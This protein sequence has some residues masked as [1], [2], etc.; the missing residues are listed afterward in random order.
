MTVTP[1]QAREARE[2]W[3]RGVFDHGAAEEALAMVANMRT[4]Y[5]VQV[6]SE[7]EWHHEHENHGLVP[8][9]GAQW[10]DNYREAWQVSTCWADDDFLTRIVRRLVSVVE[11][12]E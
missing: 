8:P 6:L 3:G 1:E 5:A 12:A 9:E 2:W 11:V 4:E 7:G 10:F